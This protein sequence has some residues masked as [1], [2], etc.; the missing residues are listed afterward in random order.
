MDRDV[1]GGEERAWRRSGGGA[2]GGSSL[3]RPTLP[4]LLVVLLVAALCPFVPGASAAAAGGS[5]IE[6]P[7]EFQPRLLNNAGQIAGFYLEGAQTGG[8]AIWTDGNLQ[9][10]PMSGYP[11]IRDFSDTG[12]ILVTHNNGL[13]VVSDAGVQ[14]LPRPVVGDA[15]Q[16]MFNGYGPRSDGSVVGV[17]GWNPTTETNGVIYQGASPPALITELSTVF[18]ANKS[19]QILGQL[20]GSGPPQMAM[21]A[22]GVLSAAGG[23]A[24]G[25]PFVSDFG[26]GGHIVYYGAGG[27]HLWHEGSSTPL[28]PGSGYRVNSEGVV[29][30]TA[31]GAQG[32]SAAAG[33]RFADGSITS[34]RDLVGG[35]PDWSTLYQVND[36]NDEC[37]VLGTGQKADAQGV[38]RARSFVA[39][40]D[41]C[42]P[43][44]F[45][46]EFFRVDGGSR[47]VRVGEESD[48][49]LRV[50]NA[51][52]RELTNVRVDSIEVE[53]EQQEGDPPEGEDP[54]VADATVQGGTG[55]I[56]TL[57]A[58]GPESVGFVDMVVTGA[59]G[60]TA[61]IKANVSGVKE[62][63][64]VT[65]TIE[66][67]FDV[68]EDDLVVNL[69]LD[70][71]EYE[72]AEDGTFEPV[73]I[74]A[75][76]SFTNNTNEDMT[77]LRLQDLDVARV[78]S[79]Q[80][81]HVTY[82]EG[83][84]PDPIDP[85]VIVPLLEP[86]QT[87]AEF[88]A[89]FTATDDGEVEFSALAT[90]AN[91][92]NGTAVGL[93]KERW[94]AKV[95]KYVEIETT[96]ENPPGNELLQAGGQ[97]II[98]GTV[99]NL[100]NNY[101]IKLGPLYPEL[102]GNTGTMN[103]GYDGPAANPT[104]PQPTPPMELE[105]RQKRTFQVRIRT[106]YSDPRM[107]EAEPSGGTRAYAR[108]EP[109]GEAIE[110]QDPNAEDAPEKVDIR[111][112]DE[113]SPGDGSRPG[114]EPDAQVKADPTDLFKRISIDDSIEL[115][116]RD[117]VAIAAGIMKGAAEGLVNAAIAAVYAI[118][119]LIK[120]P[121]TILVAAYDYQAKVWE[122]FTPEEK[123]LFLTET[124][125][126]I[127]S[128]L[129][130][131][132]EFGLKDGK[133]LY[134]QVYEMAGEHLTKTQ[135]DWQTGDYLATTEGYTAFLSEQ[136]GSVAGPVIL[137]KMAQS[138]KAVA[139]LERLQTA[140][141]TRMASTFAQA[142]NLKYVDNVLPVLQAIENGAEPTLEAIAKLWGITPE[143]IAE[144]KRICKIIGC[145]ATVR[146]RHAS[147]FEWI[148]KWG[149]LLKP[150]N[151][152]IKTVNELDVLLGYDVADLGSVVFR[153]PEL[154]KRHFPKSVADD[155]EAAAKLA[156][157]G[158]GRPPG[159]EAYRDAYNKV[160][161]Q[162]RKEILQ[163][164][165]RKFAL[166]KG[167]KQGTK[168]YTEAVKRLEDRADEWFK[169]EIEYKQW[170]DRGWIDTTFNYEGN[171][172]PEYRFD[173]DGN[174]VGKLTG[175]DKGN[176]KG[177]RMV[178]KSPGSDEFVVQM[179][180]A[181][182]GKW[183]RITG[184][185]D[186]V[187]FTYTD[188][189]PLT[190]E[191]HAR[192][193]QLL[194]NSP[195]GA[196]HGYTAT[197]KGFMDPK[198]GKIVVEP[199]PELVKKQ[200]K[201]NEPAL[202]IAPD[203][204]P[205][206]ARLD[207]E[208]S[209]WVDPYNYNMRW[210]N[211]FVDAGTKRARGTPQSVDADF[212]LIPNT[213][214]D[215]IA[216][217]VKT[218]PPEPT[219]GRFVIKYANEGE[220]AALVMGA[221]GRLQSVNPDGTT[222]DSPLNDE[223]FTEGPIETITVAPASTLEAPEPTPAPLRLF[224]FG[225]GSTPARSV[226]TT[227]VRTA[228][229][230]LAVRAAQDPPASLEAGSTRI[231]VS[232]AP[233][234]ASGESGFQPGQVLAVGTGSDNLE[235]VEVAAVDGGEISLED[236]LEKDHQPDEV[237]LMVVSAAGVPVDPDKGVDPAPVDPGGE[238]GDGGSNPG[239]DGAAGGGT[240]GS[241]AGGT[242]GG[243]VT[244]ATPAGGS[245]GT[246]VQSASAGAG[247]VA[248]TAGSTGSS[249]SGGALAF[250]GAGT[251]RVVYLGS[252]LFLVG[253]AFVLWSRRRRRDLSIAPAGRRM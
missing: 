160:L 1:L 47:Y 84:R 197:F 209:R 211:G 247:T 217:P 137:S 110:R 62:G 241:G 132:V 169:H 20:P 26:D 164:E 71:P 172:I 23:F 198:T 91:G 239:Q 199:G 144:Y 116:E 100:T 3:R 105:P 185:I 67:E 104:V 153:K 123:E 16:Y 41:G 200:F 14:V 87:S 149:A 138:P 96:I 243:G 224:G 158:T 34:V 39:E 30:L 178:E 36:I 189:S 63:E 221:N 196:E 12:E 72:E 173:A 117:P 40:V 193:I 54:V 140:I 46:G 58:S 237:V 109:W 212:D 206:A 204:N 218:K 125:F 17:H 234:L 114:D 145:I 33:V 31:N 85:E 248:G 32:Q 249:S 230:H 220:T 81:L 122:S 213:S 66:S 27:Y 59:T 37:D 73:D 142:K 171:A 179:F 174:I 43:V 219:L 94:K 86:G 194:Q 55:P 69:T 75:T 202:Q 232:T 157:E 64:P 18:A 240:D 101:D 154:V 49:R 68:R 228:A 126:L 136:I 19:G 13:S 29:A 2:A 130:R 231:P 165:A 188:G 70:P 251:G 38:I 161:K 113:A 45:S 22:D 163:P 93:A 223:A 82:K 120:M 205:R 191:D 156:G 166:E 208:N 148:K 89:V 15:E 78:F 112:Y 118:P 182:T 76:V 195:I 244:T 134:D 250:T 80:T 216:L 21:L 121:Y 51:S 7:E 99:E 107:Y 141:N 90:A 79:G 57:A 214:P 236:P 143:E 150:E 159:S 192:L 146:S 52:S 44:D 227:G 35:A 53:G 92:A 162:R 215:K 210:V 187:D 155:I 201:P 102:V 183:R 128:V 242:S 115:P 186:P 180:D 235:L 119:D 152:K 108:F 9:K 131:N 253:A 151:L 48:I 124:S 147:S 170:N 5:I 61:T 111:T 246:S 4:A 181:K 6:L 238:D 83:I 60:G 77:D 97:I 28:P 177:F 175:A 226:G 88:E 252:L 225:V 233:G 207:V 203:A 8:V 24:G 10:F 98:N 127:V 56:G 106:N 129:Q 245:A 167:F 168:E 139:A 103:V 135:N 65:G 133:E 222:Q 190:P 42:E 74:T 11:N 184:D 25:Y 95:K 50:E 176:Y 229:V